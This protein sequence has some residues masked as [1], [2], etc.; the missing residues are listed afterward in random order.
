MKRK[1]SLKIKWSWSHLIFFWLFLHFKSSFR[2][3]QLFSGKLKTLDFISEWREEMMTTFSFLT[4]KPNPN[5][6]LT[7]HAN[8]FKKK[9]NILQK[10]LNQQFDNTHTSLWKCAANAYSTTNYSTFTHV[11]LVLCILG[12][13]PKCCSRHFCL[14]VYVLLSISLFVLTGHCI[15][16]SQTLSFMSCV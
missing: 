14:F 1:K 12:M 13:F 6:P 4:P 10:H 5:P 15:F 2:L 11:L 7:K 9:K 16:P 8:K 3:L